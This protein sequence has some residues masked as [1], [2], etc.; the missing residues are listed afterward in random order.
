MHNGSTRSQLCSPPTRGWLLCVAISIALAGCAAPPRANPD[1]EVVAP[2][3]GRALVVGWGNAAGEQARA[4]LTPAQGTRV[5]RLYVAQAN[6]QKTGFG[7]NIVRLPP[8]S[9]ALTIT[10][11][12]YVDYRYFEYGALLQAQLDAGRVYRLRAAPEGRRCE[13]TLEDVTGREK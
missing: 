7:E 5:T 3:P 2:V 1:R 6:E 13:Q 4:A 10:C 9:Y 11:G 8:G 12:I